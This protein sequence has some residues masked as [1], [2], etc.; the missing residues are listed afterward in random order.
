MARILVVREDDT[1]IHWRLK[2][3]LGAQGHNVIETTYLD[4]AISFLSSSSPDL[5][6]LD[7]YLSDRL[8][9]ESI[10][11]LRQVQPRVKIL[12]VIEAVIAKN[13]AARFANATTALELLPRPF[14]AEEFLERVERLL[15]AL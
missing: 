13:A 5:V 3:T 6:L 11:L 8:L 15:N 1:F 9:V 12:V 14:G 7:L 4:E 10:T 2:T